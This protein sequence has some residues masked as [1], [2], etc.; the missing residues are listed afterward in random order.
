MA[1]C[2]H[3]FHP[4]WDW[5]QPLILSS[6]FSVPHAHLLIQNFFA[7]FRPQPSP[8]EVRAL[9]RVVSS[10]RV[11]AYCK[12]PSFFRD[13]QEYSQGGR[14]GRQNGRQVG[15]TET[16]CQL[17]FPNPA[18]WRRLASGVQTLEYGETKQQTQVHNSWKKE[19]EI[20]G[21][22]DPNTGWGTCN[23]TT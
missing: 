9:H 18:L 1:A 4:N 20:S 13:S 5:T 7:P 8:G 16:R 23:G 10:V 19:E 11:D 21:I 2:Q 15:H 17:K 12:D 14:P 3:H 22:P 6:S